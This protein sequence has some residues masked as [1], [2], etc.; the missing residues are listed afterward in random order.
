MTARYAPGYYPDPAVSG[1]LRYWNGTQWAGLPTLL[2]LLPAWPAPRTWRHDFGQ[3]V[4]ILAA[5]VIGFIGF[6]YIWPVAL[7]VDIIAAILY[8]HYLV[9]TAG[10]DALRQR[11]AI[12]DQLVQQGDARGNYG[13]PR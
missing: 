13:W 2:L 5:I 4:G 12:Q 8:G 1:Q 3:V 7:P 9:R 11:C 6:I 10:H